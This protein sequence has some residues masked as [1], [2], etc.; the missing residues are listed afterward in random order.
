M[1]I[2]LVGLIAIK[3]FICNLGGNRKNLAFSVVG[4]RNSILF[5][6]RKKIPE[7]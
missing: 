4:Y 5:Y 7:F 2:L 6:S 1:Q 3:Q